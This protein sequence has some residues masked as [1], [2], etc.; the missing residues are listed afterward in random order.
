ML[1]GIASAMATVEEAKSLVCEICAEMYTQGH[2][3]GTGGGMSIK[4]GDRI[5][6]APSGSYDATLRRSEHIQ[7]AQPPPLQ[8]PAP[9]TSGLPLSAPAHDCLAGS[10]KRSS[11]P[12]CTGVPKE[13]MQPAD[14]FVLNTAGSILEQPAGRQ[15]PY[16]PPK[17]SECS[18]LF[19]AVRCGARPKLEHADYNMRYL[20]Q[21]PSRSP[22]C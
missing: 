12:I 15:P 8:L 19:M 1:C 20:P 21:A 10:C 3:S 22:G 7:N 6:M 18:P 14:M 13:R 4:A 5:V 9:P 11:Q 17:L 16:K 2:V